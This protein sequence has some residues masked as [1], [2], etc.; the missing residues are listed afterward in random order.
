LN[1]LVAGVA[2]IVVALFPYKA[3]MSNRFLVPMVFISLIGLFGVFVLGHVAGNA[4][5]WYKLGT[6]SLQPAEFVKLSV[7][8]YL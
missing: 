6:A 8:V 3:F 2:F 1:L 5:S 4:Q 7:I